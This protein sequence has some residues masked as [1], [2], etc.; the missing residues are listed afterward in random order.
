MRPP[1]VENPEMRWNSKNENE[2][3]ISWNRC[4]ALVKKM[5]FREL[6]EYKIFLIQNQEFEFV[7]IIILI[8]ESS[9]IS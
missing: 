6:Y 3:L 4:P 2:T 5:E 1:V 8:G 9:K 7:K